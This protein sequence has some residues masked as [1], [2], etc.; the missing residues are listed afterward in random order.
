MTVSVPKPPRQDGVA[1]GATLPGFGPVGPVERIGTLDIVRG[2]AL[3][4]I[5]IV[6]WT[7][8]TFWDVDAWGGFGSAVDRVAYWTIHLVL[9][10]KSYQMFTFL[11][12]V[13]F[14]IQMQRAEHRGIGFATTWVRRLAVLFLIG[15]AHDILTERDTLWMYAIYGLLLLPLRRLPLRPLVLLALIWM[16]VPFV[17]STMVLSGNVARLTQLVNSH[18]EVIVEN[19]VLD[20]Y[21]GEYELATV[22]Y[23][24]FV[25][26]RGDALFRQSP[27]YPG[28]TDVPIRLFAKSESDFF[29]RSNGVTVSFQSTSTGAVTG[30]MMRQGERTSTARLVQAGVPIVDDQTLRQISTLAPTSRIYALGTFGEVVRLRAGVFWDRLRSYGTS[31][32]RWL[33]D[34][35]ALFLLGMYAGRKRIFSDVAAHRVVIQ[36]VMTWGLALGLAGATVES[37]MRAGILVETQPTP[38]IPRALANLGEYFGSP[39]LG[40]SYIAAL[41]LLLQRDAWRRRLAPFGAVGRMALTNYLLQSVCYVLLFFGYGLGWFGKVGA[42]VGTLLALSVFGLQIVASQWWLRRFR[43]GPAEWVWR[44]LTYWKL[45]PWR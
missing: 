23:R 17:Q 33:G 7:V 3:L 35:F 40:L 20:R 11:F 10:N 6:N 4:C 26:R 15:A 44:T 28:D 30:L 43:F 14:A 25:F 32:Q 2:F 18:T 42:F 36:R 1:L 39:L 24:L 41:T 31:Y 29:S 21:V 27:G 37:M 5:L 34:V 19:A 13:G 9:D 22:P 16:V 45:Q 12:G 8:N 38:F